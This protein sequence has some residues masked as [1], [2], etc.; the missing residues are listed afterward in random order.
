MVCMILA[1]LLDLIL[2]YAMVNVVPLVLA[3]IKKK[4]LATFYHDNINLLLLPGLAFVVC[5]LGH[6]LFTK[7][8]GLSL[9]VY[10]VWTPWGIC[11]IDVVN[12]IRYLFRK[13]A[14][15]PVEN[16]IADRLE[17]WWRRHSGKS[18][19]NK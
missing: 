3:L 10:I 9:H 11:L 5:L 14:H 12:A 6:S 19:E 2:L 18:R 1:Y 8:A 7:E 16:A 15:V 17:K 4:D 13:G